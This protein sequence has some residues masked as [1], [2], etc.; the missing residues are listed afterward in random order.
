[1]E[2]TMLEDSR[3]LAT[4][5]YTPMAIH[6]LGWWKQLTHIGCPEC[7]VVPQELHDEGWVLVAFLAQIVQFSD[8]IVKCGLGQAAGT[9]RR[10]QDLVVEDAEVQSEPQPEPQENHINW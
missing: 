7:E 8:G 1:M 2:A 5:L 9:V 6:W 4:T 3:R 10:T